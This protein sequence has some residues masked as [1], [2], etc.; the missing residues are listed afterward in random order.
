MMTPF[1]T[2]RP[3]L[4]TL[5]IILAGCASNPPVRY[6]GI[7]S[8]SQLTP[9]TG[10]ESDRIPYKYATT[11]NWEKYRSIIVEP[12]SI[13]QGADN[14]FGDMSQ[15]DRQQ[16]ATYMQ[17]KFAETLRPRF[18]QVSAPTPDALRLKLTLT[19]ADTT[20]QVVGTVTKFDL[21]GGP[22]NIVQSIRGGQGMFSGSVNYAVEIYDAASNKLLHAYVAKQYPNALNISATIG[23][24]S[25]AEVGIDKGAEQLAEILK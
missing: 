5:A 6:T 11:V 17:K 19:G 4:L 12:V 25:A 13:Y 14:Q 9:N 23:S 2:A 22:Y 10:D 1:R 21:A 24:L 20:T 8:A 15:S 18:Q 7:D 16:L 3:A